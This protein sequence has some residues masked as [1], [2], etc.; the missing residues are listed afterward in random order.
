LQDETTFLEA[1]E[2]LRRGENDAATA[3]FQRYAGRLVAVAKARLNRQLRQK[4]DPEDVVQSVFRSFFDHLADGEFQL[5]SWDSLW[6]LLV[7]MAVRKCYREARYYGGA[8]RDVR[9]ELAGPGLSE[10]S[11]A[12]T[13]IV[14]REPTPSEAAVLADTLEE[15]MRDLDDR[16]RQILRL[17]LQGHT[18]I[19][20]GDLV[21]FTQFTVEGVLKKI[22]NR[23]K[24]LR[25]AETI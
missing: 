13:A 8:K 21:G 17:R 9:K 14:G 25:D 22:R 23:W 19:E 1:L 4:A 7:V 12:Q 15:L 20:I 2:R 24:K 6:G 5:K 11:D 10:S 18:A 3:V 16:D